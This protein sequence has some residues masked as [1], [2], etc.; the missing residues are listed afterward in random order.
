MTMNMTAIREQA[1]ALGLTSTGKMRKGDLIRAIQS[2]EGNQP[3]F[4]S[5]W[6]ASCQQADCS[7]RRDCLE[8]PGR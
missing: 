5:D 1:R 8:K 6:R 7:W 2:K 3:C 4:E